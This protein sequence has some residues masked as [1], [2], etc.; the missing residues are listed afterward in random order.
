VRKDVSSSIFPIIYGRGVAKLSC[1]ALNGCKATKRRLRS[2]FTQQKSVR[3]NDGHKLFLHCKSGY[4]SVIKKPESS[5]RWRELEELMVQYKIF[6]KILFAC[7]VACN[8]TVECITEDTST[9]SAEGIMKDMRNQNWN[10]IKYN[11]LKWFME[12]N[13]SRNWI[14]SMVRS[15]LQYTKF[16]IHL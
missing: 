1:H 13:S 6:G 16:N 3:S 10:D 15:A 5:K 2:L 12:D 7:D 9:C 4:G 11:S 14:T 8:R